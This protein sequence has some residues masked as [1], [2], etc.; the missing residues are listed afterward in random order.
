MKI[1]ILAWDGKHF[2][3]LQEAQKPVKLF[4]LIRLLLP[5]SAGLQSHGVYS[6]LNVLFV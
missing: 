2:H 6:L 3:L 1:W 4:A 5:Y